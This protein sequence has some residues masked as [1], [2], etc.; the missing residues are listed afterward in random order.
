MMPNRWYPHNYVSRFKSLKNLGYNM[1]VR[2]D[3]VRVTFEG[4]VISL[5]IPNPLK[6]KRFRL[7]DAKLIAITRADSHRKWAGKSDAIHKNKTSPRRNR[8][9]DLPGDEGPISQAPKPSPAA[10][11]PSGQPGKQYPGG[12]PFGRQGV[13]AYFED[14]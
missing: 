4:K 1:I 9:S 3:V 5:D 13:F 11:E 2:D 14:D 12:G 6:E 10:G 8:G 7:A